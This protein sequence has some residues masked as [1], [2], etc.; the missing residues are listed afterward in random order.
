MTVS[1]ARA[2]LP[3]IIERVLAGEE[4]TLTRHGR[5]VAVVVNPD[6][7][8]VRRAGETL[9]VAANVREVLDEARRSPLR[10]QPTLTKD[11]AE[12]LVAE[13]RAARSDRQRSATWTPSTPTC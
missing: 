8:R 3:E 2:A 11:R 5:P 7:L 13:V 4:V 10:D 1:Q 6:I 9:A 12:A